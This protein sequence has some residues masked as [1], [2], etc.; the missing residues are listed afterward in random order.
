MSVVSKG[1]K[2]VIR[3]K[4]I[5]FSDESKLIKI[6]NTDSGTN[7]QASRISLT[8]MMR[9]TMHATTRAVNV[10]YLDFP[11]AITK[12]PTSVY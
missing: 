4:V 7:A 8:F 5:S 6:P 2:I 12:S 10:I 3:N 9:Y 11:K 1:K